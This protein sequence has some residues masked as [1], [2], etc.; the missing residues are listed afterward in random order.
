MARFAGI[1]LLNMI[2]KGMQ[3]VTSDQPG[4]NKAALLVSGCSRKSESGIS[5]VCDFR[6]T[7]ESGRS[8]V[9]IWLLE[10]TADGPK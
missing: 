9:T 2:T 1:D 4:I 6:V 8:D 5:K 7:L 3:K 10:K